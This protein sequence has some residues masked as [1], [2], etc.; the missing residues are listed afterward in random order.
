MTT[1]ERTL[2]F[3][4]IVSTYIDANEKPANRIRGF[5]PDTFLDQTNGSNSDHCVLILTIR[6]NRINVI[7]HVLVTRAQI[8][9][10]AMTLQQ[11]CVSVGLGIMTTSDVTRI[12][13]FLLF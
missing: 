2:V 9:S 3:I 8:G 1:L 4:L 5:S 12:R 6:Q 11:V 10:F 7:V 13:W